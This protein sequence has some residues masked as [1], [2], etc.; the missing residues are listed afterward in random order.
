MRVLVIDDDVHVRSGLR[1]LLAKKYHADVAEAGDGFIGVQ[2]LLER[3][4][5]LIVLDLHMRIMN[6]MDTLAAIRRMP[7]HGST[8][9]IMLTGDSD[10]SVVAAAV[11]L[12][13]TDFLVKP[14]DATIL[15]ERI[16]GAL[17]RARERKGDLLEGEAQQDLPASDP[18]QMRVSVKRALATY[19]KNRQ[20]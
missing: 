20:H 15:F 2:Y 3:P 6:G 11:A 17:A 19:V 13:V 18:P 16:G 10:Q 14:V 9:I 4:C 12:G 5:D 8:P 1:R 7:R